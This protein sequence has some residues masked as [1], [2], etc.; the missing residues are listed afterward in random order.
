MATA[1]QALAHY[2]LTV[3]DAR[4]FIFSHLDQPSLIFDTAEEFYITTQMLSEISGHSTTVISDYFSSLGLDSES[5]DEIKIL[6]NNNLD[7]LAPVV[8]F[9][10][11]TGIL[12][13]AS[14]REKVKPSF[15]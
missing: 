6:V 8:N 11:G 10:D 3:E 9:N 15:F 1:E 14:L 2:G 13:T 5:L 4:K 7:S 12:S